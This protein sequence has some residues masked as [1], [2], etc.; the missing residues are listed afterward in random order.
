MCHCKAPPPMGYVK[1]GDWNRVAFDGFAERARAGIT[2]YMPEGGATEQRP[3]SLGE[4][5]D[6]RVN[7]WI[8][9]SRRFSLLCVADCRVLSLTEGQRQLASV[10]D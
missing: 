1:G 2:E 9:H 3:V 7:F 6:Y 8:F 5:V 4:R 10:V